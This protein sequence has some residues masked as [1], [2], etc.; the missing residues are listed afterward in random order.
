MKISVGLIVNCYILAILLMYPQISSVSEKIS[1]KLL[2]RYTF[3]KINFILIFKITNIFM[4]RLI[5]Y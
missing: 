1:F 4:L 2:L 5:M 3:W